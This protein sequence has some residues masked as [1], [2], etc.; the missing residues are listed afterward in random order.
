MDRRRALEVLGVDA[1]SDLDAIKHRFRTL[2]LDLHPDRGGDSRA[3]HDLQL[4]YRLLCREFDEE[5]PPVR[6]RV[7]Q[8]RPSRQRPAAAAPSPS[9]SGQ[10]LAPLSSAE[11]LRLRVDRRHALDEDLLAR[12]LLTTGP[13]A[14]GCMLVSRAPRSNTRG[15][16]PTLLDVG[17]TSS[18]SFGAGSAGV[19]VEL[20][21][22]GRRAR[23]V[24]TNLNM[25]ALTRASWTRHRG[26]AVTVAAADLG[27]AQRSESGARL[28]VGAVV[29]L[30]EALGWPLT[31]WRI[32][33]GLH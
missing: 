14:H 27:R 17:V 23:R 30:L 26:D 20:T 4:A 5:I 10:P 9:S 18:L 19:R 7:A 29:E 2:V 31:S 28:V 1:T 13:T 15:L 24:L 8:G 6:T 33:Q 22:R 16:R 25:S 3:F 12:L 11:L 32:D 21:A